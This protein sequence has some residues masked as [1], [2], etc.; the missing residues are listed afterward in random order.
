[1]APENTIASFKKALA[2]KIDGIEFDVRVSKDK[3]PVIH[4]DKELSDASGNKLAIRD[5]SLKELR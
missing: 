3:I 4:H 2:L 1:M 5:G